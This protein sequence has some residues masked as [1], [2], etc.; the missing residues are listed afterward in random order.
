MLH[1]NY[2]NNISVR[3]WFGLILHKA[4]AGVATVRR[5]LATINTI[6]SLAKATVC[7][8]Y[9]YSMYFKAPTQGLY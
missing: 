8:D 4:V 9:H 1:L 6:A 2:N 7:L 3:Y 5:E